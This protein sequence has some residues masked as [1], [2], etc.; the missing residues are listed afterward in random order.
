MRF[1]RRKCQN[2]KKIEKKT[3]F[4]I[5]KNVFKKCIPFFEMPALPKNYGGISEKETG[6]R[7][8]C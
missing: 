1:K 7:P 4:I 3:H 8:I 6:R 2:E 5:R